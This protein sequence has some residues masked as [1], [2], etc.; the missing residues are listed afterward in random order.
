MTTAPVINP[1]TPVPAPAKIPGGTFIAFDYGLRRIG[2]A[3]GNSITQTS[4]PLT[5]VQNQHGT[6]DWQS[7]DALVDEWRPVALLVGRLLH[8]DGSEQKMTREAD[9]FSKR[10]RKR[11]ALPVFHADERGTSMAANAVIK[12]NRQNGLRGRTQ[13]V[14]TDKI[15]A[16]LI[17]QHWFDTQ[18]KT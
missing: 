9:G 10:V 15:A 1:S 6:P 18:V 4:M 14:D 16:A 12:K 13:K 17:L 7:I 8:L 5:T 3:T 11:Y 2:I